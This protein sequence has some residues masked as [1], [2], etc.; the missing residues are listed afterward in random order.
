MSLQTRLWP[1][2]ALA[3]LCWPSFAQAGKFNKVLSV[4]DPAPE[5]AELPGVDGMMHGMAEYKSAKFM[6]LVFTANHCPFAMEY[7]DRLIAMQNDFADQGVQIV[8]ISCSLEEADNLEHMQVRAEEKGF[9]FPY[10]HDASQSTGRA[11]GASVTPQ[12]FVLDGELRIA[13]MGAIDDHVLLDRVKH[14]YLRDALTTLC[15]GE[16][17]AE[18]ETKAKGC[19]IEYHAAQESEGATSAAPSA[20]SVELTE[21]ERPTLDEIVAQHQGQVVLV[22]FW[23]T[24][25]GP[26]VKQFPHTV[27]LSR[28]YA[29]QGLTV[30]SVSFDEPEDA[31]RVRAFLQK[32]G[33]AFTNLL[34]T[35]GA[36]DSIELFGIDNGALPNYWLFDRSGAL[37]QRFSPADPTVEFQSADLDKAIEKLLEAGS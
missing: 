22:D 7:E 28:K 6:V 21:I 13:Y 33:A 37:V 11:Y 8:A 34:S 27:E 20:A 30:I 24:W 25:C 15:A 26:C 32:Q 16:T 4:G 5:F 35:H 17:P 3:I 36:S 23:A 14:N 12:V 1:L 19:G 31:D 2:V 10:L 9:N 18:T 29:E